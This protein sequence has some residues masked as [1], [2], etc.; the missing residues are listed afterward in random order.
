MMK[1]QRHEPEILVPEEAI[2]HRVDYLGLEIP[3]KWV[4]GYG[5]DYED[6]FRTLPYIGVLEPPQTNS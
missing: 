6:R 3:D 1:N 4:V 2:A 5:L